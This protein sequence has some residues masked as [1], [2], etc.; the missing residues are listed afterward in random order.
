MELPPPLHTPL[1]TTQ[2]DER[3]RILIVRYKNELTAESTHQLY[4]WMFD[5]IQQVGVI[6]R[7]TIYDFSD[8]RKFTRQ[9]MSATQKS[10]FNMNA[11]VDLSA[12]PVAMVAKTIMQEQHIMIILNATPDQDRK[13]IVKSIEEGI[14][15]IE[16]F[17]KKI[18]AGTG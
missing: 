1:V 9:N 5:A 18:Q 12:M 3:T 6:A 10:S 11:K 15:F 14:Q 7:G 4:S 8:V 17:H 16:D 13:K 2:F